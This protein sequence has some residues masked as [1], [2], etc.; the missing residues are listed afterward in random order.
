MC[1]CFWYIV[2]LCISSESSWFNKL[3]FIFWRKHLKPGQAK[4]LRELL[5]FLQHVIEEECQAIYRSYQLDWIK[6]LWARVPYLAES[7]WQVLIEAVDTPFAEKIS[8]NT[9]KGG[10]RS[11]C[12]WLSLPFQ[13]VLLQFSLNHVLFFHAPCYFSFHCV[14]CCNL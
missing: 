2:I 7:L 13:L 12:M 1:I 6:P 9:A 4:P 3:A 11:D 8:M 14:V 5:S 10:R